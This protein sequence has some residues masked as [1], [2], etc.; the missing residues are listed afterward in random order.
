MK[1]LSREAIQRMVDFEGGVG[2]VGGGGGSDLSGYATES[3]VDE[4]YLSKAF[5]NQI[6][7]IHATVTTTVKD[8][9]GEIIS[10]PTTVTTTLSP[11]ALPGTTETTDETTGNVTTIVTA[12]TNIEAKKGLWTNFFLSA[13]GQGSGGGGGGGSLAG[14]VDVDLSNPTNGQALVYNA[15]SQKWENQTIGGGGSGTL[16]SIGLVMPTGFSV[17]PATLTAD[18]S[19]TV[20]FAANYSLPKTADVQK[21]VTA[22]GWGNHANAGYLT[23]VAFS[24]L[25]SHPTTLAGY[26][27][28]DAYTKT[29][30]DAKFLTIAGFENLFNAIGS[31]GST[32]ID[33]PYAS[34]V[35]SI[36][37]KFG[38]WTQQYL[39]ALGL[40]S[41]GSG[42][43]LALGD[44]VD[45]DLSSPTNGQVLMYDS[46]NNKWI[47]GTVTASGGTVTS[48]SAGTGL[49]TGGS[50]ITTSGTIAI[51][52]TYLQY[53]ADGETAYGW[54][55]H[56]NAGYLTS[57][58]FSDLTSHPTTLA[59][60]GI[61]DAYTKTEADAKF[62]TIAAFENLF[63]ALDSNGDPV[64]HPYASGVASIK[65]SVGLWTEQ[66]LSALGLNSSGSGGGAIALDDL[67]NVDLNSPTN[68]QV[69]MYD[70]ANNKWY[71]G[72]VSG[73]GG[74]TGTVTSIAT[75]TGLT[76]GPITTSGTISIDSTYQTYIG[77]GETAYGW[78][79]HANAGYAT[80]SSVATQMQN[81]AYISSGTIHIGE[82][83][84]NTS[85]F[86][87]SVAFS[88]L[89][90]H[91][92]TLAGY[93]ITD[94]L[95][96]STSFWGQTASNGVV[97]GSIEAGNDG[98]S[99]SGFHSIE[100]NTNGSLSGYGGFIDFHYNGSS[101][102]YT[103]RIIEDASGRLRLM[104]DNGVRIGDCV[105]LWDSTA[106][107]LK[108][109][110]YDGTAAGF[111]ATG[112]VSALGAQTG[113]SG[114]IAALTITESITFHDNSD[115]GEITTNGGP[116]I[117]STDNNG[118]WIMMDDVCSGDGQAYWSIQMDG[119]AFFA[120]K[121]Q[122]PKFYLD[123]TRY[124]FLDSGTLK[125]FDG[126]NSRTI[127][128]S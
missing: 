25:T 122:S 84:I 41:S 107:A 2:G 52:T 88:D 99:I 26:G 111:Y 126:T 69:L 39:S 6:F 44:L 93:G 63:S 11:N 9:E 95:N 77:H 30:A 40:N 7:T 96:D 81:Y 87:T 117:I 21:G 74:G 46:A 13:L 127:Q 28:T 68:G 43:T 49:T 29:E 35:A 124:I 27:I 97:S 12:I 3:W 101:A 37:A 71:N 70:A 110:R 31:D 10:G 98:G 85:N 73:G 45:V 109:Q 121:C 116:L 1:T 82:S 90:S 17:S 100:L 23:S 65:A 14:L 36:K 34:S 5:W 86:L 120:N 118:D 119:K 78:G 108:V 4:N 102:D 47:N 94:A 51:D 79:N 128:L 15:T 113:S 32:K 67:V 75:G 24:D 33:H 58:S 8:S 112:F 50:A 104:A 92:N 89:T 62:M 103:S 123:S 42:A 91:P 16:T 106:G 105:L 20:S 18:G 115:G 48:I 56:A 60:Y 38:L 76:G 53:I 125:Y 55:N 83:S 61:T 64:S 59:G 114:S 22:Y 66:Y 57:V 19:F 72:T 54:G 80:P